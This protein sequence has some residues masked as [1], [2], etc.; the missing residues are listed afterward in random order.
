MTV[1]AGAPTK[2]SEVRRIQ[3]QSDRSGLRL[4]GHNDLGGHGDGFQLMKRGDLV[5]VGHN[6]TSPTALSIVDCSDPTAPRVLRQLPRKPNVRQHKVQIVGNL[7]V[8][9]RER[10]LHIAHEAGETPATGLV[11]FDLTD[12]LDPHEIGFYETGGMGAHKIWFTELPYAHFG[13]SMPG[14][15]W[16]GYHIVDLSEPE[17]PQ[18]V[19]AWWVPGALAD[20]PDPWPHVEIPGGGFT[21]VVHAAIPAGGRA[22]AACMDSGMAILDISDPRAPR[23]ISR[24]CWT[25]PYGG[26][27]HTCLPLAERGLVV[28]AC[29]AHEPTTYDDWRI[30]IVDVREERQ[31]VPISTLPITPPARGRAYRE[32]PG[33]FGPHNLHENQPGSFQ[34]DTVVFS[35]YFNAGIRVH[36]ISD[37]H[38]PSELG[39]FVPPA[40]AR[41]AAIQLNDLYVDQQRLVYATD[42]IGGGL[43][44]FECSL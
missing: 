20:D 35:T 4:L 13:G 15:D 43:Y 5:Y 28:V 7:L 21:R 2:P 34:S 27:V 16:W 10:A 37:P 23:E 24:V 6:G 3:Y 29:E 19:G 11:V 9:N 31:P 32:R 30:W 1:K 17:N 12:P 44:V 18:Q 8:Q 36:D 42:R 26:G 25:P 41:Q 38:R 14:I 33:R 40:P 39:W 22:Y